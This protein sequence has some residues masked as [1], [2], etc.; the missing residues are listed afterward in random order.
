MLLLICSLYRFVAALAPRARNRTLLGWAHLP[1]ERRVSPRD[2][3][4]E[5]FRNGHSRS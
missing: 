4:D 2:R 1:L 5:H 3:F